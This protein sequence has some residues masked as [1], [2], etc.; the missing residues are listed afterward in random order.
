MKSLILAVASLLI[1]GGLAH[2]A[3]IDAAGCPTFSEA[4][5]YQCCDGDRQEC[6]GQETGIEI[7]IEGNRLMMSV[8]RAD[9]LKY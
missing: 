4:R 3:A 2:A 1:Q 8:S 9:A 5:N 6:P 7:W